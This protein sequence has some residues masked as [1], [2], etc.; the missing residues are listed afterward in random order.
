MECYMHVKEG[1]LTGSLGFGYLGLSYSVSGAAVLSLELLGLFGVFKRISPV[2]PFKG[3]VEDLGSG[4][5]LIIPFSRN[6]PLNDGLLYEIQNAADVKEQEFEIPQNVYRAVLQIYVS[7]HE[8]DEFWYGNPPNDYITANNNL[9]GTPGNGPFR[10]LVVS[11]DG[12]VV[13]LTSHFP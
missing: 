10:E 5:D 7:F 3:K 8:N 2:N 1:N 4:A 11:L 13:I 9:T 6:L 12:E